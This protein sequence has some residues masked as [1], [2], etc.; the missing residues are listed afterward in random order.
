MNIKI[1]KK[2]DFRERDREVCGERYIIVVCG[3]GRNVCVVF[4]FGVVVGFAKDALFYSDHN[5]KLL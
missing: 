2:R 1:N 5:S 3:G 4:G